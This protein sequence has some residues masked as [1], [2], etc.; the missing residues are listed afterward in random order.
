MPTPMLDARK[1]TRGRDGAGVG[2]KDK[3][4]VQRL[5]VHPTAPSI[6][7]HKPHPGNMARTYVVEDVVRVLSEEGLL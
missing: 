4:T 2:R 6:A 5:F 1:M 3:L 7:L